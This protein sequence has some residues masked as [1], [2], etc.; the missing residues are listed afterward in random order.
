MSKRPR[1]ERKTQDRVVALFTDDK[2][3]GNL[4]YYYLGNL[5]KEESA[6]TTTWATGIARACCAL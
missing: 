4:G 6:G 1:S 5:S 2:R 3:D